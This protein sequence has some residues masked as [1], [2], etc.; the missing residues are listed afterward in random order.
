MRDS[1][2]AA[3]LRER[4]HGTVDERI[5]RADG[6]Q[7]AGRADDG[8]IEPGMEQGEFATRRRHAHRVLQRA[9]RVGVVPLDAHRR[10]AK[11]RA[12][13]RIAEDG[14]GEG[15]ESL[16][17]DVVAEEL[18]EALQIVDVAPGARRELERVDRPLDG[19]DAADHDL[20]ASPVLL[21]RAEDPDY[22]TRLEAA[23]EQGCV[24][25]DGAPHAAGLIPEFQREVRGAGSRSP[26]I[27][28]E[29]GEGRIHESTGLEITDG[30]ARV[31]RHG[32]SLCGP[33]GGAPGYPAPRYHGHPVADRPESLD[34][35]PFRGL[36]YDQ[37]L[38]P[39][40]AVVAPP[41]DVITL[42]DRMRLIARSSRNVVRLILPDIGRAENARR[43]LDEWR[44]DGTLVAEDRPCLYRTEERFVGP[45]GVERVR[46]G[47]I[48]EV[49]LPERERLILPHERTMPDIVEDRLELLE[50]TQAQP[51]PILVTYDDP[52]GD[53]DAALRVGAEPVPTIDLTDDHGT[54]LRLWRVSDPAVQ[55]RIGAMLA[56]RRLLIADGHHR[57]ATALAY[58][59]RNPGDPS[60]GAMM[61]YL[62]NGASPGLVVFPIHRVVT[63]VPADVVI[64]LPERLA[65]A[66]FVM[67]EAG[68]G[69]VTLERAM[70]AAPHDRRV[71][72][73]IRHEL[74]PLLV[75]APAVDD[76][77]PLGMI[78]AAVLQDLVLGPLLD[79]PPETVARTNRIRYTPHAD[80]AAALVTDE[81]TVAFVLRAPSVRDIEAVALAERAMPQ[82]STYFYPKTLDG[83]VIR[84]LDDADLG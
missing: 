4:Q 61:M 10:G 24:L 36:R 19:L 60:A 84:T 31:G 38:H 12:K 83:L 49:G 3:L 67:D 72:G 81:T 82:K 77:D 22:V 11:T 55:E 70:A 53:I 47:M 28:A 29:D 9:A 8:R 50:A 35:R 80:D 52:N 59:D 57:Y 14:L 5:S 23:I 48:A 20:Q 68:D 1:E 44:A 54:H 56:S 41:Y 2:Q 6:E 73:L 42:A 13:R 30:G 33:A 40:F 26:T 46:A 66:G 58:R 25:E 37:A 62:T 79:L 69:V 75:T 76:A 32:V 63:E 17:G 21:H 65:A 78:D 45:D 74:P 27:L 64:S 71:F 51:S 43:L 7:D 16:V 15:P 18:E 34:V 39:A